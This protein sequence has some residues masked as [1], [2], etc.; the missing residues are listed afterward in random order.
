MLLN[1]FFYC[2]LFMLPLFKRDED[3]GEIMQQI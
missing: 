1:R 2:D 3:K